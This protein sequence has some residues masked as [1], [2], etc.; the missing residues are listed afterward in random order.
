MMMKERLSKDAV[1]GEVTEMF[2]MRLQREVGVWS[3][4]NFGKQS[5]HRPLLGAVEEIGEL[6]HAHL[7]GEQRIRHTPDEIRAMRIDAVADVVIYL[8]DYCEREGIDFGQAVERTWAV[9]KERDW[10]KKEEGR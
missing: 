2:L 3:R 8:A 1:T 9:V 10:T 7:K 6:C 4:K 5:S